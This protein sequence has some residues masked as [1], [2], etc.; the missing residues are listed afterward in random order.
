MQ[1]L[2]QVKIRALGKIESMQFTTMA[3]ND[4]LETIKELVELLNKAKDEQTALKLCQVI[5]EELDELTLEFE[6]VSSRKDAFGDYVVIL[7]DKLSGLQSGAESCG[8][9]SALVG[10]MTNLKKVEDENDIHDEILIASDETFA[11]TQTMLLQKK[12]K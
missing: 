9:A 4:S 7:E 1:A 5:L 2:I 6:H 11:N 8:A 3:M 12:S 10:A